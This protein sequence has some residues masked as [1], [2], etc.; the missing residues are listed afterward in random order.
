MSEVEAPIDPVEALVPDASNRVYTLG[1]GDGQITLVQKPLSFFG[2]MEFF[3]V[4]GKAIET[5][6]SEGVSISEILETPDSSSL[7]AN[8][9]KE[10]DQFVKA[11]A[12]VVSFAPEILLDLYCV[13]LGVPRGD[14]EY[15]K[16]YLEEYLTD[17]D[18]ITIMEVFVDQNFDVM[19]GFFS[20]RILPL[21]SRISA[22]FQTS[23]PSKPSKATPRTTRKA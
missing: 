20:E 11:I 5:V 7:D 1:E 13:I 21:Y 19:V 14:R 16:T 22:K 3:S 9:L 12:T 8:S 2:K 4:M 17:D 10:A 15:V 18:G 23:E 6:L